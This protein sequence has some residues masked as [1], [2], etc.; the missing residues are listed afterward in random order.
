MGDIVR[1]QRLVL[2][3][4]GITKLHAIV[5][6]SMGGMQAL[7]WSGDYPTEVGRIAILAAGLSQ[8]PMAI[9]LNAASRAC[10]ETDPNFRGGHYTPAKAQTPVWP[11][12][13]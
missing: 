6:G 11:S 3:H 5:G 1:A 10:V 4:L 7:L 12:A 8:S 13:G 2:H 9:A